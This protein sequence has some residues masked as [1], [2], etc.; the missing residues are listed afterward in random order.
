MN[1]R[2]ANDMI[3][4]AYVVAKD[5]GWWDGNVSLAQTIAMIHS[6]WSEALDEYRNERAMIYYNCRE[7]FP[8][9]PRDEF[10]CMNFEVMNECENR[11][12]KPEGV[13]VEL[14]DGVIRI[15][16]F[17]GRNDISVGFENLSDPIP[18]EARAEYA[19]CDLPTLIAGL[20]E[21]TT[22]AY[23]GASIKEQKLYASL[24]MCVCMVESWIEGK[25]YDL[26]EIIKLKMAYNRTRPYRH[27]GKK[28]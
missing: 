10:D 1:G 14:A 18:L 12:H 28:C 25:G 20:H 26:V 9:D 23:Q 5:H 7:G 8:C 11:D 4:E 2:I 13:A 3:K 16:D 6:E 15:F 19:L 24:M 22:M 27:G 17:F 21:A